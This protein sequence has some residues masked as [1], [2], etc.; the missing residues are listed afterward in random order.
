MSELDTWVVVVGKGS[1]VVCVMRLVWCGLDC[2]VSLTRVDGGSERLEHGCGSRVATCNQPE[3]LD[4]AAHA[5][6][7]QYWQRQRQHTACLPFL[8]LCL[9]LSCRLCPACPPAT[10]HSAACPPARLPPAGDE[11]CG[12]VLA[13][14]SGGALTDWS[15]LLEP[16]PFFE[17]FKHFL[18]VGVGGWVAA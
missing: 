17:G 5:A 2:V 11:V 4:A 15:K 10:Q 13:H 16:L 12:L 3:C 1:G 9:V 14:G 8:P 6:G 7:A 18:Q